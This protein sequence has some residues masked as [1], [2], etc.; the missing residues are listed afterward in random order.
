M[1]LRFSFVVQGECTRQEAC[2]GA[3]NCFPPV[4]E[5]L[6]RK[7][8]TIVLI[9]LWPDVVVEARKQRVKW[10]NRSRSRRSRSQK[11]LQKQRC[12]IKQTQSLATNSFSNI[13]K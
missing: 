12:E 2:H 4:D 3:L 1:H 6:W 13:L 8:N 7:V 5:I 10:V 11:Q 9:S